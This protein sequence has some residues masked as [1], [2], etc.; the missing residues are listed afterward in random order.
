HEREGRVPERVVEARHAAHAREP[1]GER[2]EEEE[3]EDDRG[4][5][6]RRV[7]EHVVQRPPGDA[8]G[9]VERAAHRAIL[10]LKALDESD[11][12]TTAIAVAIPK[13]SASAS[14]SQPVMI[15]LRTHSIRYETGFS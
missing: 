9:D 12:P 7:R 14:A 1:A 4:D 15:R 11:S 6:Q 13:P 5:Q 10:T 3:R 8:A 2:R